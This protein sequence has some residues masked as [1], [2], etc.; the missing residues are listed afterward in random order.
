MS[1]ENHPDSAPGL[2]RNYLK[3]FPY[4]IKLKP[5]MQ[6]N[7][8]NKRKQHPGYDHDNNIFLCR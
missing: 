8:C 5:R 1:R 7:N 4:Y 2:D 3:I 6:C